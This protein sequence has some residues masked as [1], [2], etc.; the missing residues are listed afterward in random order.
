[1]PSG[2]VCCTTTTPV[3]FTSQEVTVSVLPEP[4]RVPTKRF[5]GEMETMPSTVE[6]LAPVFRVRVVSVK[7]QVLSLPALKVMSVLLS[8]TAAAVLLAMETFHS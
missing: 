5:V 6:M 1:M 2:L 7:R 3:M 4:L 8:E